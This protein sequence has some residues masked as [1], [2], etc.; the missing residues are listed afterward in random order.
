MIR[1][2]WLRRFLKD[3][4]GI[5][6]A[7][8]TILLVLAMFVISSNVFMWTISQNT[9]YSESVRESH[10]TDADRFNEKI[11][12]SD[13][14]YTVDGNEVTVEA[15]L[16]NVGSVA[17]QIINLWVFDTDPTNQRYNYI[18]LNLNLNPGDVLNLVGSSGVTVTIPG[19]H[20]SHNFVSYFMTAR[21]NT[22]SVT[23]A[24]VNGTIVSQVALGIGKVGMDFD[25]FVYYNAS[26]YSLQVWPNGKEGFNVPFN[27]D[28]AFRVTLT[29]FDASKR[30]IILTSHS[31]LWMIF[32][33][34]EQQPRGAWWYIVNVD[35]NG[36]I[37]GTFTN[38]TL[39]YGVPTH[40]FFASGTDNVFS[41]S[42]IKSPITANQPAAVN[43]M[44]FGTVDGSSFGQN[45][46]FVSIYVI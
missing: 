26:G 21:G 13:G 6:T 32:P 40:V 39:P 8:G 15:K 27:K 37:A 5:S 35:A 34:S 1:L 19:A 46:P 29:N 41:H 3:S 14:N 42:R 31:V 30:T 4:K 28:I 25:T 9:A 16:T 11:V 17:A 24:E 2:S 43:L 45:I 20:T 23:A 7:I 36:T 10:Q 33:A 38:I 22:V 18:S 12:A 44:L